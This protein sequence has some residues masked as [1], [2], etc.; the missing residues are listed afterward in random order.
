M[1]TNMLTIDAVCRA[2]LQVLVE[3]LVSDTWFVGDPKIQSTIISAQITGDLTWHNVGRA[4]NDILLG[5]REHGLN[6]FIE[7]PV[8]DEPWSSQHC[9]T[10]PLTHISVRVKR[11]YSLLADDC[12]T[13]FEVAMQ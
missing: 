3:R 2:V 4:A 12:V 6:R 1:P 10:D 8:V 13:I 9:C 7:M 11:V 5:I